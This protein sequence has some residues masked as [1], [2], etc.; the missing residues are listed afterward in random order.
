MGFVRDLCTR[1]TLVHLMLALCL[2]VLSAREGWA[3]QPA[4]PASK[5]AAL[6]AYKNG[7]TAFQEAHYDDAIAQYQAGY[8]AVPQPVFLFNIGQAYR[9]SNRPEQ[10]LEYYQ[11][12][13][14]EDPAAKNHEEVEGR[15]ATL[16]ELLAQLHPVV[17]INP[18]QQRVANEPAPTGVVINLDVVKPLPPPP[19]PK[20][21]KIWPIVVGAVGGAVVL[22]AAI[23]LGVY[24][25]TMGNNNLP[26][27]PVWQP[28]TP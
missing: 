21:R 20:K 15:I 2:V 3:G 26:N 4:D 23:G 10:A 28:V 24:F 19:P 9:L 22:G 7:T 12:Y 27:V 5:A 1:F 17:N 8:E 11:R 25:G 13:L 18:P 16:K 14:S 6:R